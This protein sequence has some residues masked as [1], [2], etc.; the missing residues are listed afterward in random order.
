M[1]CRLKKKQNKLG[2]YSGKQFVAKKIKVDRQPKMIR[3][4][5]DG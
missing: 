1:S 3:C 2:Q 5:I 4:Q